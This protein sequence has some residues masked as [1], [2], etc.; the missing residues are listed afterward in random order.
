MNLNKHLTF[1]PVSD[2]E[3]YG[4]WDEDSG[5]GCVDQI[6]MDDGIVVKN[7]VAT[8]MQAHVMHFECW[9][10]EEEGLLD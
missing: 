3:L 10:T 2:M 5:Y 6:L 8:K 9:N 4:D 1:I 7:E